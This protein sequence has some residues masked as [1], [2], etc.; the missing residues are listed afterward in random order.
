MV[1]VWFSQG[2][3]GVEK[4]LDAYVPARYRVATLFLLLL[5]ALWLTAAMVNWLFHNN[6]GQDV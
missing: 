5:V 2:E 1:A 4:F 3:I 6:Q